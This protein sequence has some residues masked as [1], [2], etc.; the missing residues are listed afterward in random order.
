MRVA[1]FRSGPR[2]AAAFIVGIVLAALFTAVPTSASADDAAN[3]TNVI[4][5]ALA[6]YSSISKPSAATAVPVPTIAGSFAVASTLTAKPG[7]WNSGTTFAYQWLRDGVKI[8]AATKATYKLTTADAGTSISVVVTGA[9]SGSSTLAKTSAASAKVATATT[10]K[11]TGT[12][13]VGSTLA[14]STGAWTAKTAFSY[15]W[16]RDGVKITGATKATYVLTASDAGKKITVTVTG[17]LT[18]YATVA[19]TSA[20][21]AAVVTGALTAPAPKIT[22]TVKVGSVLTAAAGT[23]TSGTTVKYQWY[24][25]GAAISGATAK[26]YTLRPTDAYATITV[27]TTGTKPGYATATKASA[28]TTSVAGKVY[29][30]CSLLNADYPDGI[31]KSGVTQDK[32]SGVLKPVVGNPYASTALYNLQSI[33]RD[34]DRDGIMCER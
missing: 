13:K 16:L 4:D 5:G 20:V 26:T 6:G 32:K 9:K 31:R 15:Q 7:A 17:K 34:A 25:N 2:P 12:A 28:A 23:W 33:A 1:F 21:T 29:A 18:G 11:I 8:S 19:K 30:N 22:G 3:A 10:P 24:R 14:V 27:K